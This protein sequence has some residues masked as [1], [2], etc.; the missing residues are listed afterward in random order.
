M[1]DTTAA[2]A[3]PETP[4]P[5]EG[6]PALVAPEAVP[7]TLLS[8]A[9]PKKGE[10]PTAEAPKE[11]EAPAKEP[12]K[13]DE[14]PELKPEDYKITVP[15]GFDTEDELYQTFLA[16]AAKGGLDNESVQALL[17]SLLP[18]Y[19]KQIL[20][21][22]EQWKALN[23]EW[24]GQVAADPEIGGANTPVV[25]AN[26]HKAMKLYGEPALLEAMETTGAGNNPAVLR[27]L[28]RVC[29]RLVEPGPVMGQP[30]AASRDRAAELYPSANKSA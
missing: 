13:K 16:G 17:D 24:R 5:A 29:S 28:N 19:Q 4:N 1:S 20:A 26:I 3:A 12:E 23:T 27:F 25:M 6:Q 30:G 22:Y 8:D 2:P 14:P 21:P 9:A 10:T 7:P 11:G 15:E 18:G